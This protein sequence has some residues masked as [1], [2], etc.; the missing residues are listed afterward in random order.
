VT[1]GPAKFD[2]YIATL[3]VSQLSKPL[4]KRLDQRTI[5]DWVRRTTMEKPDHRHR[6][7]LRLCGERPSE[8]HAADKR[9][10]LAPLHSITSSARAKSVGGIVSPIAFAA[11]MLT[12][13]SNLTGR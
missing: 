11:F 9:H 7:L 5:R 13:R 1:L 2:R 12:T 3:D 6:S 4:T 8:C 10:E